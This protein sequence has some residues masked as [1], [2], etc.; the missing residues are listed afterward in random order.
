M[1]GFASIEIPG[2]RFPTEDTPP[3]Y[4]RLAESDALVELIQTAEYLEDAPSWGQR[5]FYPLRYGDPYYRGQGRG[6]GRGRGRGRNW[7][8]KDFTERDSGGGRGRISFHGNGRGQEMFQRTFEN[9][10]Q[11]GN[12][13]TSVHVE[14]RNEIRQESQMPLDPL[15]SRFLDWSSLGSPHTITSPHSAPD[16]EVEQN[17]NIQNQLS[18]QEVVVPRHETGRTGSPEEV[19]IFP[20]TDQPV[21]DQS[22]SAIG[23]EPN[24]LHIEVR[25]QRDDIGSNEE[26]NVPTTQAFGSVMPSLNVGELIPSLNAHQESGNTSD[27]SG[28]SHVRTQ[29][30]NVQE[31][32][33]IPPVERLTSSRD[34]RIVSENISIVRHNPHEGI[35]PQRTSTSNRRDY[36]D[37]S[38]DDNRSLRG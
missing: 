12:W 23:V 25:T 18:V 29:N 19:N 8:N 9:N 17:G 22:V 32:S 31:I 37:D 27:T 5:R 3:N 34:R 2:V 33:S 10:R 36:L 21:E 4:R 28:G 7:L 6:C 35:H 30:I 13:L 1:E 24:P 14:G 16:I 11:G 15:P 26:N 20:Q 38:S